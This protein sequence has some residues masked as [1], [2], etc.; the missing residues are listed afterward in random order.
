MEHTFLWHDYETFGVDARNDRPAQFAAIRTDAELNEIEAPVNIF[1]QPAPDYLPSPGACLVTGITP[2]HCLAHGVAE[3][4]FAQRIHAE[5]SRPNTIGVGYNSIYFDDECTRFLLWRNL[6]E[7]YGREWQNGCSRWDLLNVAR[8]AHALRPDGIQWAQHADGSPSFR[9]EDL[10]SANQLQHANAHDALSDVH[11]T[12]GLARALKKAQPKLF[13][14]ALKLRKKDA[15]LH[16]MGLPNVAQHAQP[17]LH[18]SGMLPTEYGCIAVMF[19][20]AHH[21]TNRNEVIAWDLR[22]NPQQLLDMSANDIRTRLFTKKDDLPEGVQRLPIKTIHINRAPMVVG[23]LRTLSETQ[24]TRWQIDTAQSLQHAQAA[25]NLPD[26]SAIWAE[27]F[28]PPPPSDTPVDVDADLYA[29]F[30]SGADRRKL[31]NIRNLNEEELAVEKA[32]FDDSRLHE[33]IW[34]YRAR[35]YPNSLNVEEQTRWQNHCQQRLQNGAGNARTITTYLDEIDRI[36]TQTDT[37]A[38]QQKIL[39]NL[40]QYAQQIVA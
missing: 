5:L 37:T 6:I 29:G 40:R 38:K 32:S 34:R 22:H 14:F 39:E 13:E 4:T 12:L 8:L 16:E 28:S 15:V 36:S 10:S 27:V 1:C 33:L 30:L 21:P 26:M 3:N 35:N 17:F 2:Q 24:A 23:N 11:A 20:L 18:V 7:P 9:L 31:D 25:R 19:P